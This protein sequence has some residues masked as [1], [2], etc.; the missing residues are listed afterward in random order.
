MPPEGKT[1]M[2]RVGLFKEMGYISIGDKYTVNTY[3]MLVSD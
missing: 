3:S 1:D 2:D